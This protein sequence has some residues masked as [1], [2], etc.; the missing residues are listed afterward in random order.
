MGINICFYQL[1][2]L[3]FFFFFFFF[4]GGGVGFLVIGQW[5]CGTGQGHIFTT[6]LTINYGNKY[7]VLST[8]LIG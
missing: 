1:S 8:E 2:W 3:S 5:E 7:L 4:G 6:R